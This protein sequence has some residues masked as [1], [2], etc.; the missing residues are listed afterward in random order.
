MFKS[1]ARGFL[2]ILPFLVRNKIRTFYRSIVSESVI[3]KWE[4]QGRPVPPPHYVKQRVI[5]EIHKKYQHNIFVETGTYLGHMVEAQR[6]KFKFI[7]SVEIGI[8]LWKDATKR[9]K[10]YPHIEILQGDSGKMLDKIT[11][12]LSEP[13]IFWLDGHYSGGVTTVGDT[14]C[15]IYGE[16]DAIFKGKK[17]EHI[18][19]VDDARCFTGQDDYPS[20]EDLTEYVH[21]KD[22]SY[23]VEVKDDIA[24]C[25]PKD[26]VSIA[27]TSG[28]R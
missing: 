16:I 11:A 22:P 9:F 18:I 2:E 23:L 3:A 14:K 28:P 4:K 24:R 25:V 12:Q 15:P 5:E 10:R 21:S 1:M 26:C 8:N 20:L 7:Y 6:K 17:L 27:L 19:L 13:A